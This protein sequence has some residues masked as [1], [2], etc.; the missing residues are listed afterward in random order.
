MTPVVNNGNVARIVNNRDTARRQRFTYDELN[1]IQTARTQA[2]SRDH[3]WGPEF[4]YDIWANLL[5]ASVIQGSA[6]MLSVGVNTKNQINNSGFAYDAAGN[7]TADGSLSMAYDAENRMVS[8]NAGVS[9]TYDGDG[10]RVA[11]SN[12][13]LYWYGM[14]GLDA[15]VETD[16]AGNTPTE[17]V[18]FNGRRIARRDPS[19]SVFYYFSNHLGSTSVI[20]DSGGTVVEES[21]YYPFGG[22]RVVV[23]ND[24][25]PY[26]F[27]GKERD[28]ETGLDYFVARYY[29]SSYGRFLSPDEF[30]G[31][32]VS[33]YSSN[34]PLPPGPLPYAQITNPQSLNKYTYAFNDPL[35]KLDPDG[36]EGGLVYVSTPHGPTVQSPIDAGRLARAERPARVAI[37]LAKIAIGIV[38]AVRTGGTASVGGAVTGATTSAALKMDGVL[39]VVEA[40]TGTSDEQAHTATQAVSSPQ[41]I[42]TM[43]ATDDPELG[44]AVSTVSSGAAAIV[45]KDPAEAVSA[46]S[47]IGGLFQKLKSFFSTPPPPDQPK[48]PPPPKDAEQE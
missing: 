12:G 6:P 46:A 36:H 3:A 35:N 16:S 34:D 17:Y 7:L 42:A 25:N 43:V 15:L 5:S 4:G 14:S 32:P 31:G 1:R 41:G 47:G 11:K 22:E 19:G 13:K 24:P 18:F 9:Y 45:K 38:V 10:K 28:A 21:D 30:T 20:T 23:N 48:P 44:A 33:A 29:S 40:S 2:T 26:K 37:G 8:T 27:T 39:D